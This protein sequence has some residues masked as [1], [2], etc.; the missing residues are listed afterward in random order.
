MSESTDAAATVAFPNGFVW[1]VATA[2]YQI[3]GAVAEHGR[4]PSVWD[5]FA[6]TPGKISDGATG[7]VACDHYH[8]YAEDVGLL[9]DLGVSHYRFSL[10]WPRLQPSG[11]GPLNQAGVDFYLRLLDALQEKGVRPWVTLYHWDLPQ[12]LEDEGGW[13]ARDTAYRFADYAVAVY[14][15][16]HDRIGDWTTL[17]EP[18]C[19]AY[20]GYGNGQHAPGVR[21]ERAA[22]HAAHHLLL[23]HG[24]AV[25]GMR[26]AVPDS[27]NR[28]GITLNLWPVTPVTQEPADVEAA[29]RVDGINNRAFL[30]PVLKGGYPADVLADVA[31]IT[32]TAHV[33]PGDE[34]TIAAPIDLLGVNYYS[35]SYVRAGAKKVGGASPWIGCDDVESV[36]QGF[37]RTDMGWEVEPDGLHRLLVRLRQDY[38]PLPI[39]VT[40]NGMAL[41]DTVDADGRVEDPDR[42]A[43]IDAHLRACRQAIDEGVDLRGYF[44]WTLTDNFEWSFGFSKRFGL[45]HLD[46][47][48]Q[49]RTPKSSA[50]WYAQV[51]RTGQLP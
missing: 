40:E 1:G 21:D 42:I 35:P 38:R 29:R 20:L 13:P 17:N 3:E 33:K 19:S 11:R 49:V 5:T 24:L 45:V 48:T 15:R 41:R 44:V 51:A 22:L 37:P 18:W 47:E 27:D 9:A 2:S 12:A 23:G 36:P 28:I 46:A 4:A 6:H 31:H 34:E 25:R 14:E 26:A 10:A 32:D 50:S 39:Y 7:D 8:R 30:D 43:Y 16:L